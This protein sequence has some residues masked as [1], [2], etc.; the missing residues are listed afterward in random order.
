VDARDRRG[1]DE[2]LGNSRVRVAST[3]LCIAT[4]KGVD[5]R[6]KRG[7]DEKDALGG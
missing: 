4:A 2:L 1:H 3:P 6:D 7:H 5:A